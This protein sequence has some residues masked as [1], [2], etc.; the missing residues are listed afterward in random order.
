MM[1]PEFKAKWLADLRSGNYKQTKSVLYDGAGYCC[2]GVLCASVGALFE[3]N[4]EDEFIG[5]PQYV[6]FLTSINTYLSDT[7]GQTLDD[8]GL[9]FFGL[10]NDE[11]DTLTKMNDGKPAG[12][13]TWYGPV[14]GYVQE[15]PVEP[16]SFAEIADWIEENL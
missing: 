3:D 13:L 12:I 11:Q 8:C 1:K 5:E 16:K 7:E 4:T 6:P 10:T 14:Q 15:P 9:T 2:L